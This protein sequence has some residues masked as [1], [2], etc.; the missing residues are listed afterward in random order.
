MEQVIPWVDLRALIEPVYPKAELRRPP[1][2]VGRMQRMY[3]L[4][5]WF[6]LLDSALVGARIF[7]NVQEHLQAHGLRIE[8]RAIVD[9]TI[10]YAPNPTKNAR[11]ER[12]LEM[13]QMRKGKQ[14]CVSRTR[15]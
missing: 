14:G 10:V 4:Q 8:T 3:F 13:H 12:D 5:Q 1:V 15:A 11:Q 6:N 7:G 2:G 9:V